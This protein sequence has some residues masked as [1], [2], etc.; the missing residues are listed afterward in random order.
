MVTRF[1]EPS[2]NVKKVEGLDLDLNDLRR[3][4]G[5]MRGI[6][7][8]TLERSATTTGRME[9]RGSLEIAKETEAAM[10]D[11]KSKNNTIL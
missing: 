10:A 3:F 5:C 8:R 4:V 6:S 7:A 2:D 11:K 9:G 1:T